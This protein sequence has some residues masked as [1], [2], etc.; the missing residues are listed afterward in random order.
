[1]MPKKPMIFYKS[2]NIFIIGVLDTINGQILSLFIY[3]YIYV[4]L[5]GLHGI[6]IS[7][8]TTYLGSFMGYSWS[9]MGKDMG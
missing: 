7:K 4:G 9:I 3:T 2:L 8:S 1:M 6:V 5:N